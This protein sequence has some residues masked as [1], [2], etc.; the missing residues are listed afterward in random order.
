MQLRVLIAEMGPK[1]TKTG[2]ESYIM[3]MVKM[4]LVKDSSITQQQDILHLKITT[5][6]LNNK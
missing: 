2:H 6:K 4:L 1:R 5:N 3:M